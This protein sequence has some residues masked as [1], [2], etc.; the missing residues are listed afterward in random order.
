MRAPGIQDYENAPGDMIARY[1]A[2]AFED[3]HRNVL[4]L[5][6]SKPCRVL[7]IGAGTGRDAAWFAARGCSVIAVEPA[8]ALRQAGITLH[9]HP[10]IKWLDDGLPELRRT[11]ARREVFDLVMLTGVWMHLD[12]AER[13]LAMPRVASLVAPRGQL[14]FS[15]RHGPVPAG[16]RM[17]DVSSEE[18]VSLAGAADLKLVF[19]GANA[20]VQAGPRAAG[21]TW[22]R[23][24]FERAG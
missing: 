7:D 14:V 3:V 11:L 18:T 21:V 24:A 12:A 22:T 23:L 10:A 20:S 19:E 4:Q 6:P 17:F 8:D 1:D 16:R 5:L 9:P 13:E 15:L 2:L